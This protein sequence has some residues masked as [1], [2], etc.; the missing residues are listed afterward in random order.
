MI[1]LRTVYIVTAVTSIFMGLLQVAAYRRRQSDGWLL[2]W[3]LSA[4]A[5]GVGVLLTALQVTIAGW[6][7]VHAAN[8]ITMLAYVLQVA[9][10]RNFCGRPPHVAAHV[11][12]AVAA[13]VLLGVV[14][15][16]PA[17][18]AVRVAVF[19]LT[20]GLCDAIVAIE[21][22]RLARARQIPSIYLVIGLFAFSAVAFGTR[23]ALLATGWGSVVL[24]DTG[25]TPAHWISVIS[26][27]LLL[28]RGVALLLVAFEREHVKL[29]DQA[30]SDALTG[31]RNR[32]GMRHDIAGIVAAAHPEGQQRAAVI[33]IDV[34]HFKAVN[35]AHGHPTGDTILQRVADAISG[36]VGTQGIAG[37]H[38]GDEFLVVLPNVDGAQA[39]LMAETI[40]TRFAALMTRHHA[41][42]ATT[43]SLGV[44]QGPIATPGLRDLVVQADAALYRSKDLGRDRAL[45]A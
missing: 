21:M 19:C 24:F 3:G 31:L 29:R 42:I 39:L 6:S 44:A 26:A 1:D 41:G 40:R 45:S 9:S 16:D 13:A 8:G 30:Y 5:L 28:A 34:D 25:S 4:L 33:V 15:P 17:Q 23:A 38:G 2:G 35:D 20:F 32:Q 7:T 37:R 27:P 43:I 18:Y 11:A 14:F 10:V 36:A 22:G 12:V